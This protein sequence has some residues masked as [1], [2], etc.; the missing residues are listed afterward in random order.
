MPS[1]PDVRSAPRK[2]VRGPEP[3]RR[4]RVPAAAPAPSPQRR[5]ILHLL[6]GFASAVLLID[7]FVGEKGLIEGLRAGQAYEQAAGALNALKSENAGLR[8]DIQQLTEDPSAIEALAREEL[9]LIRQGEV[10]FILR[11]VPPHR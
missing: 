6:L 11:D 3:L 4:K 5:K 9:G 10:L 2:P 7:A 8:R 1:E